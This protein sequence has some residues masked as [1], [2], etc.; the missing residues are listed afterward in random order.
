MTHLF[1]L[2]N[3]CNS[4]ISPRRTGIQRTAVVAD[5]E[6]GGLMLLSRAPSEE[7]RGGWLFLGERWW[8]GASMEIP[9]SKVEIC[10]GIIGWCW[11][12]TVLVRTSQ[13]SNSI[14]WGLNYVASSEDRVGFLRQTLHL[15]TRRLVETHFWDHEF[16]LP[17][18][19]Q[20]QDIWAANSNS[21]WKNRGVSRENPMNPHLIGFVWK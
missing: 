13:F 6:H 14:Q 18:V 7:R 9:C 19:L 4:S 5:E 8:K 10:W 12:Y 20:C 16:E 1:T 11:G 3:L 17:L 21:D 15:W 2:C